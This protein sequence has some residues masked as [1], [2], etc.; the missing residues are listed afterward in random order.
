VGCRLSVVGVG[1]ME[2]QASLIVTLFVGKMF[3]YYAM[4]AYTG[5]LLIPRFHCT[6]I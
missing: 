5:V 6:R 2:V 4:F 3:A 1:A